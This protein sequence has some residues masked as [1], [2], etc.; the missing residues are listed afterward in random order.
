MIVL[1]LASAGGAAP[2]EVHPGDDLE[3]MTRAL[4]PGAEVVL[5]DGTYTLEAPLK[6]SPQGTEDQ[7]VVI[8]A[9]DGASPV[10][11]LEAGEA[12]VRVEQASFFEVQGLTLRASAS[13]LDAGAEPAGLYVGHSVDITVTD[14]SIGPT[15]SSGVRLDGENSRIT[16]QRNDVREVRSGHG[17]VLGCDDGSCRTED[18]LVA[19]NR[20]HELGGTWTAGIALLHGSR[21]NEVIHNVVHDV[22][23]QGLYVGS[24]D[25]AEANTVEGNVVWDAVHGLVLE[26]AATVRNNLVFGVDGYGLHARDPGR[27]AYSDLVI[28]FN[29]IADTGD[30]AA[31][32]EHFAEATG[33]VFAN[34]ALAN[35]V[36]HGLSARGGALD[37]GNVLTGNVVTGVVEGFEGFESAFVP[38]GGFHDF[39][40]VDAWDFYPSV[41]SSL[42]D[43]ADPSAGTHPPDVDFNGVTRNGTAPD[44]GAY[45]FIGEGNPGWPV[46]EGF[47]DLEAVDLPGEGGEGGCCRRGT[48]GEALLPLPLLAL[49]ARRRRAFRRGRPAR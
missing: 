36:G 26:G 34:N 31:R 4:A 5:H 20:V 38:G 19:N 14:C 28:A 40:D 37:A 46:Q 15:G 39:E 12:V 47:K 48:G 22:A 44:V 35:P 10:L 41:G 3:A 1:L 11:E 16:L 2:L 18:S 6:W 25:L 42:R 9:A 32:L 21:G 27:G 43:A 33:M 13:L 7:P 30:Y 8:R 24:T 23:Y 17:I 49:L 45:E 29:T